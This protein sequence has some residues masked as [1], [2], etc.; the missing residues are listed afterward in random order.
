MGQNLAYVSGKPMT[1]QQ[2]LT[3][4]IKDY[5]FSNPKFTPGTGHFIQVVWAEIGVGRATMQWWTDIHCSQLLP[6]RK[7]SK[8]I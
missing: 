4:E 8:T 7:L 2:Q 6:S 1:G 5:N 3:C